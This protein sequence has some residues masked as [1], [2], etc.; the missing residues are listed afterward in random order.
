MFKRVSEID[1]INK[2]MTTANQ[3]QSR[4]IQ[5]YFGSDVKTDTSLY[6]F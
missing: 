5:N 2:N 6:S 1:N 4:K 3:E